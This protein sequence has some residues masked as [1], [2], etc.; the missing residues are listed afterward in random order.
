MDAE[1]QAFKTVYLASLAFGCLSI[2]AALCSQKVDD[3]LTG[4]VARKFR[5]AE[6]A[7]KMDQKTLDV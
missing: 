1:S 4:Y 5:G 7:K 3:K 6:D 2:I